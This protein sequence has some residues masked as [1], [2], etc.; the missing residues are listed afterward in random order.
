MIDNASGILFNAFTCVNYHFD[1]FVVL[2]TQEQHYVKW[3][4]RQNA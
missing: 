2:D 3:K 1:N 4:K